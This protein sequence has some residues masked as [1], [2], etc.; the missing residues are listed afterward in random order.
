[1]LKDNSVLG[2]KVPICRV[3]ASESGQAGIRKDEHTSKRRRLQHN[4]KK[5][6]K[7]TNKKELNK[8]E[9]EGQAVPGERYCYSK[10]KQKT[11]DKELL[12]G[13]DWER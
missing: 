2:N 4:G 8:S 12:S 9:P 1:M 10:A 7:Q 3:L 5:Y 6:C 11:P 13:E